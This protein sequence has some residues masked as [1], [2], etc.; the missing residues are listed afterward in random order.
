MKKSLFLIALLIVLS[1]CTTSKRL[2]HLTV[3]E[4]SPDKIMVA[5][6]NVE[7]YESKYGQYD[8]VYLD[9]ETVIEHSGGKGIF[10]GWSFSRIIKRKF[11]VLNPDAQW[12][13]SFRVY[14]KPDVLYMR[15]ITHKG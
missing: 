12:L 5:H 1:S 2:T 10:S 9:V 4:S 14:S 11:M 7:E 3:P 15:V 13:T 6:V 8:G